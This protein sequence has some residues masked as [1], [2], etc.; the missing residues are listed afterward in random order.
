MSWTDK[1]EKEWQRLSKLR[2]KN[3][4]TGNYK[5]FAI[6]C[7]EVAALLNRG[8]L[9]KGVTVTVERMVFDGH[10]CSPLVQEK[11]LK[12]HTITVYIPEGE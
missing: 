10:P 7:K 6:K 4:T 8:V 9:P 12:G 11:I 5:F 3:K 1:Q 2:E